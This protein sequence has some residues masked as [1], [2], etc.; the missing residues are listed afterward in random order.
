MIDPINSTSGSCYY[1][2][3]DCGYY[4]NSY[5]HITKIEPV[6]D[7]K[8]PVETPVINRLK[9]EIEEWTKDVLKI[10]ME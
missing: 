10:E 1:N 8:R 9:E 3:Y 2:T 5:S 6:S 7:I 4:N